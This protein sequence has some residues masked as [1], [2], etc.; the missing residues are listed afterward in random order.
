MTLA[1]LALRALLVY[2]YLLLL[3]RVAGRRA[4]SQTTALDLVVALIMSSLTASFAFGQVSAA[5]AIAATGTVL[6]LH[7]A[8][9]YAAYHRDN[10]AQRLG[11]RWLPATPPKPDEEDDDEAVRSV[12]L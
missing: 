2:A 11:L 9:S 8:V 5:A 3:T 6:L 10:L 12:G 4:L 7:L 1:A